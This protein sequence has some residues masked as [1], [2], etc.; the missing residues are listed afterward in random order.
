MLTNRKKI[1]EAV[2]SGMKKQV[3]G[4]GVWLESVEIT[5][6]TI[7]SQNLFVDLQA[8]F[9]E[10][11]KK[12]AEIFTSDINYKIKK[13]KDHFEL[14]MKKITDENDLV[15]NQ[16]YQDSNIRVQNACLKDSEVIH[17]LNEEKLDEHLKQSQE[18]EKIAHEI[19]LK[20]DKEN[21]TIG[22][23]EIE[24]DKK[25]SDLD[26][27]KWDAQFILTKFDKEHQ[28]EKQR[29]HKDFNMEKEKK[30]FKMTT[31]NLD[32]KVLRYRAF[33]YT[34]DALY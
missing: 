28:H 31:D 29:M 18:T 25:V 7:L 20:V 2:I 6:V 17:K 30:K 10:N 21:S 9:R 32:E 19:N 15:Y 8:D 33:D 4:W 3:Q 26:R 5:E 1:R 14:E 13:Q 22:L 23:K 34:K 12:D 11:K 27:K 16:F 24:R